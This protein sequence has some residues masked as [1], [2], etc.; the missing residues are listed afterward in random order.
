MTR[1]GIQGFQDARILEY[2][3]Y[4]RILGNQDTRIPGHLDTRIFFCVCSDTRILGCK[5]WILGH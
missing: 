5:A 2:W 1:N 4:A 3:D